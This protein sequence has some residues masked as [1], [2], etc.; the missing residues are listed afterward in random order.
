MTKEEFAKR[1][2]TIDPNRSG[3]VT[4]QE[5]ALIETVYAFHPCISETE[6]KS[7]VAYLYVT[8]G[9]RIFRD[10]E[11]TAVRNRSLEEAIREKRHELEKLLDEADCLRKG[12]DHE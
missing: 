7:Q 3:E 12:E 5:Y 9:M 10:M 8:F 2:R 11:E 4:P 1:V 6:G